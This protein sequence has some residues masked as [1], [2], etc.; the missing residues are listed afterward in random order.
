M[1]DLV[2]T[3]RAKLDYP[4][5]VVERTPEAFTP[6]VRGAELYAHR[7]QCLGKP[8][9]LLRHRG[10]TYALVAVS[11][12]PFGWL[13]RIVSGLGQGYSMQQKF[14]VWGYFDVDVMT[15]LLAPGSVLIVDSTRFGSNSIDIGLCRYMYEEP[16][17]RT[18]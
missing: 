5:E 8:F 12:T 4:V 6:L 3:Y 15:V 16:P 11:T 18:R 17:K 2:E 7:S 10:R 9:Q 1:F 13:S 14:R